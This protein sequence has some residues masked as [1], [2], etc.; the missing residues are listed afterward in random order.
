M[1]RVIIFMLLLLAGC[2][3]PEMVVVPTLA[4][5]PTL[6]ETP[7]IAPT[8]TATPLPEEEGQSPTPSA[9]PTAGNTSTP[10]ASPTPTSTNTITPSLTITNTASPT[11]TRRPTSTPPQAGLGVLALTALAATVLPVTQPPVAPT[12]LAQPTLPPGVVPTF[13]PLTP[14]APGTPTLPCPVTAPPTIAQYLTSNP[15]VAGSLGC[16]VGLPQFVTGGAQVFQGGLMYFVSG[17]PNYIYSLT[18]SDGRFRRFVDSWR[19]GDP[20]GIA[21]TPPPGLIQPIRGFGKVWRENSDVRAQLGWALTGEL[22][23]SIQ[24]QAFE[25]GRALYLQQRGE[26]IILIDNPD[27]NSGTWRAFPGGF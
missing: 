23:G 18:G 22:G 16:P 20:P 2:G 6:T 13:T 5:L 19:E 17:T 21:E 7:F 26:T 25:R 9:T 24:V 8:R 4:V 14:F 15:M 3:A 12:L 1:R 11:A 27:G 10:S